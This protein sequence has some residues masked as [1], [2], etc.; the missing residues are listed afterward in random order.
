MDPFA[1]ML[2]TGAL[3]IVAIG[4]GIGVLVAA[5][6][7]RTGAARILGILAVA[8]AATA[9]GVYFFVLTQPA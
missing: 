1:G 2:I 9:V 7:G 5:Q 4:A 8:T 6:R 3:P